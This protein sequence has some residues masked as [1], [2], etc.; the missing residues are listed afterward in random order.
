M[1]CSWYFLCNTFS[2]Y[3]PFVAQTRGHIA[4]PPS[5]PT[6]VRA[7]VYLSR[8]RAERAHP[9]H[10]ARVNKECTKFRQKPPHTRGDTSNMCAEPLRGHER[11][12]A[13]AAGSTHVMHGRSCM[14]IAVASLQCRDGARRVFT[15]QG[16]LFAPSAKR[17]KVFGESHEG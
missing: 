5:L 10:M 11:G 7:F 14:A 6:T 2:S 3:L 17:R 13:A 16:E 12:R 9:V 15:D 1:P 4:T 8:E